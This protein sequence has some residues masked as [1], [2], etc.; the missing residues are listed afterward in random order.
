MKETTERIVQVIR[1]IKKGTVASYGEIASLA[2]LQNG[3]R[4]V[5]RILHSMSGTQ[6]LPWWRVVKA[7]DCIA[8][9]KGGGFEEQQAL[10]EREGW[11]ISEAGKLLRNTSQ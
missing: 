1:S 3:A 10:L 8:L 6:D 7:G 9:P 11:T 2:G 5:A 4:Q